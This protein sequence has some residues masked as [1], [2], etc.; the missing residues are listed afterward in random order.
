[1]DIHRSRIGSWLH[2][3]VWTQLI[4]IIIII[5]I[6]CNYV[7]ILRSDVTSSKRKKI[8]NLTGNLK[9]RASYPIR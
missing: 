5:I 1:M 7:L 8:K 6:L 4:Y 3:L 2:D 9:I